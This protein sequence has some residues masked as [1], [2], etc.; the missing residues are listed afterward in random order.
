MDYGNYSGETEEL[1]MVEAEGVSEDWLQK[2][3]LL[4]D[5]TGAYGEV[6]LGGYPRGGRFQKIP[7]KKVDGN[8]ALCCPFRSE[9]RRRLTANERDDSRC[10]IRV[11]VLKSSK[12]SLS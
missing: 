8:S 1:K 6:K 10:K 3:Q 7:E 5:E 12:D 11:S 4:E 2:K 9:G